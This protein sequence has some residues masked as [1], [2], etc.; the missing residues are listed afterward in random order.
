MSATASD[1][2]EHDDE[3]DNARRDRRVPVARTRTIPT[4]VSAGTDSLWSTRVY[5]N[6]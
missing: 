5:A 6:P 1:G 2:G 4:I 3:R